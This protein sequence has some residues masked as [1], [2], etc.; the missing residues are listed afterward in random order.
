MSNVQF[1]DQQQVRTVSKS[2][3]LEGMVIKMGLAKDR[4]GAQVVL[5]IVAAI[6]ASVWAYFALFNGGG[7]ELPVNDPNDPLIQDLDS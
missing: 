1:E 7:S 4:K 5:I 6:A 3:G 2:K